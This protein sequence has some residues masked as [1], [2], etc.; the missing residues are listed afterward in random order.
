[1]YW[2]GS[3]YRARTLVRDYDGRTRAVERTARSKSAAEAALKIA[4]RDRSHGDVAADISGSTR[5]STLAEAWFLTLTE[6]APTTRQAYRDRLDIQVL[7]SLGNL[8]V[9]E[10]TV[11]TIDRHLR[12]VVKK[13]GVGVSKT[14]RT[15][16]SGLCGLAARHDALDRNPVRDAGRI[17]SQRRKL[18]RALTAEQV[19]QLRAYLTYDE[20][21][22]SRDVPDLISLLLA[23]GLRIGEAT[24]ICWEDVDL[25]AGT[26]HI[27]GTLV[28]IKGQ[29]LLRTDATKTPAGARVLVLPSWCIETL[30]SRG[31][32]TG[33]VFPAIKGGLRDPANTQAD[34][35]DAL[36]TAG[37]EWVTSHTLR[38]TVAT[39]MDDAGL[40]ARATADQ[41]GHA[42]PSMTQDVYMGRKAA[43]TGAAA[44][45][46]TFEP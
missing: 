21:A 39:A 45:L 26:V 38:K 9:R 19:R 35:R 10:L 15:V 28:R 30:R 33:P 3:S 5:V 16:L 23:T 12:A 42:H 27:K 41:L 22:I 6:L 25:T 44:V 8:L 40:S 17:A 29:G 14:T 1:M 46:E 34:L 4:I 18:P 24:G 43:H 37:F 11:G 36:R 31:P 13:H 7:P 2:T 20:R 32:G